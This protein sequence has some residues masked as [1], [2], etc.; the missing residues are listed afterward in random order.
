MIDW[1]PSRGLIAISNNGSVAVLQQDGT[2]LT[3]GSATS[4]SPVRQLPYVPGV[5][6]VFGAP[7]AFLYLLE[8]GS[9]LNVDLL[10]ATPTTVQ[11]LPTVT[12]PSA[13]ALDSP[14]ALGA[15]SDG[16]GIYVNKLHELVCPKAGLSGTVPAIV[17][18]PGYKSGVKHVALND[19]VG[20]AVLDDGSLYGWGVDSHGLLT[21]PTLT[22]AVAVAVGAKHAV[23]LLS[24]GTVR[25]WGDNSLGQCNVPA[26][27]TGVTQISAFCL[28]NFTLA[29]KGDGTVSAWG[30]DTDGQC[31][32]AASVTA[33]TRVSA[34]TR[35][36]VALTTNAATTVAWGN[37]SQG[38][39]TIE[40]NGADVTAGDDATIVATTPTL[41]Y[42]GAAANAPPSS[43]A[44]PSSSDAL[45]HVTYQ[46]VLYCSN[47]I[48]AWGGYTVGAFVA[49][50]RIYTYPATG[51]Y[52]RPATNVVGVS[53]SRNGGIS[54]VSLSAPDLEQNR[55]IIPYD[56][57]NWTD[58]NEAYNETG[59]SG[60]LATA[61]G[62]AVLQAATNGGAVSFWGT[63]DQLSSVLVT[64]F[65]GGSNYTDVA[66]GYY[67]AAATLSTGA[68]V[69]WGDNTNGA[70]TVPTLTN[71]VAVVCIPGFSGTASQDAFIAL[72][73][74]GTLS[75]WGFQT[76]RF[77]E[78]TTITD[79]VAI[80]TDGHFVLVL[81]RDRSVSWSPASGYVA[82]YDA[83]SEA[84]ADLALPD[85]NNLF[86]VTTQGDIVSITDGAASNL[87]QPGNFPASPQA[88][89]SFGTGHFAIENAGTTLAEWCTTA[90]FNACN[91][92][93]A[94]VSRIGLVA[95][96]GNDTVTLGVGQGIFAW[97]PGASLVGIPSS[98]QPGAPGL[99]INPL[100]DV[101]CGTDHYMALFTNGAITVWGDN[102]NGEI[103][104]APSGNGYSQIA[105]GYRSCLALDGT[106]TVTA[107]GADT[108]ANGITGV[109]AIASHSDFQGGVLLKNGNAVVCGLFSYNSSAP[110][111]APAWDDA[112]EIQVGYC[113]VLARNAG[114]TLYQWSP[115]FTSG[116]THTPAALPADLGPVRSFCPNQYGGYAIQTDGTL[117][118]WGTD[119]RWPVAP[120]LPTKVWAKAPWSFLFNGVTNF[121]ASAWY[122][123][124]DGT[125]GATGNDA[126]VPPPFGLGTVT[127]FDHYPSGFA[128]AVKAD[129]SVQMWGAHPTW[130]PAKAV[131]DVRTGQIVVGAI[132]TVMALY[133]DGSVEVI[134]QSAYP[135][136]TTVP[137]EATGVTQIEMLLGYVINGGAVNQG[138]CATVNG[139]GTVSVWGDSGVPVLPVPSGLTGVTKI[140]VASDHMLALKNDGSVEAW[141]TD[142]NGSVAAVNGA[143]G[144]ADIAATD[145]QST[146]VFLNGSVL[147]SPA[148]VAAD[149]DPMQVT[150]ALPDTGTVGTAYSATLDISGAFTPPASLDAA[151][152]TIPAWATVTVSGLH[153]DVSGTPTTADTETLTIGIKDSSTSA[154]RAQITQSIDIASN[155]PTITYIANSQDEFVTQ[156]GTAGLSYTVNSFAGAAVDDVMIVVMV[157]SKWVASALATTAAMNGAVALFENVSLDSTHAVSAYAYKFVDT[158]STQI[159]S[160]NST[161]SGNHVTTG[162]VVFRNIST[163]LDVSSQFVSPSAVATP[164]TMQATGVT[165]TS[166]GD[167]CL[168]IATPR[169]TTSADSYTPPAS[170]TSALSIQYS[171]S[172]PDYFDPIF[173]AYTIG[174]AAGAV[175]GPAGV[176]NTG[177]GAEIYGAWLLALPYQAP[178]R[179]MSLTGTAVAWS[180]GTGSWVVDPTYGMSYDDKE[181]VIGGHYTQPLSVSTYTSAGYAGSGIPAANSHYDAPSWAS[182]AING[183]NVEI[184][185]TAVN[186]FPGNTYNAYFC[187]VKVTD[188]SSP[189]QTATTQIGIY[190]DPAA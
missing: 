17:L 58:G 62:G 168:Y 90:N 42:H 115:T 96:H 85:S 129:G 92:F 59:A 41:S 6:G 82:P 10:T 61:A 188:S 175:P 112:V 176:Y 164:I 130:T 9:L 25:A 51:L 27:L 149:A 30:E 36:A 160:I 32:G 13:N 56:L 132:N 97:G 152:S 143:T 69:A 124:V 20:I 167:L 171:G 19:N 189:P 7:D 151:N 40:S 161:G 39:C 70:T 76:S 71:A 23:A 31:T 110:N 64:D 26:G 153:I 104:N 162:V 140:A 73:S 180:S 134:T 34:G 87:C 154:Q 108:S 83:H 105:A 80:T 102:T 67:A 50:P 170:Y 158:S 113:S 181:L 173:I 186:Q 95:Y 15:T 35:H 183:S 11:I 49:T 116:I 146:L 93:V 131:R 52:G 81:H 107:W 121:A 117:R 78:L 157:V 141:G 119:P 33:A 126:L 22:T 120:N 88:I 48:V 147:V 68:V 142:A 144:V 135:T 103:S 46:R 86:A 55:Y 139:D 21:L 128:A 65:P 138:F 2:V 178:P 79:A 98:L 156:S 136:L 66:L 63:S 100:V 8:S 45:W 133:T 44:S 54:S 77:P 72:K 94:P 5:V 29:L 4:G 84:F 174:G 125:L 127:A 60:Q 185:G 123:N 148:P 12:A 163:T 137:A 74:D 150:G 38:Q 114:G 47:Q 18:A 1:Q 122:L 179:D 57:G 37:N 187:T 169:G 14:L 91:T 159:C 28:G 3:W 109:T 43:F 118:A 53:T 145:G 106:G 99:S 166:S 111:N 182:F 190:V 172:A 24:D 89:R 165:T 155:V 75:V 101:K 177:G 184:S 16:S